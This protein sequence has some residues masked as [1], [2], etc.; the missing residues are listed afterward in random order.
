MFTN[1]LRFEDL[2]V[3]VVERRVG[4]AKNGRLYADLTVRDS[5]DGVLKCKLWS[6][7]DKHTEFTATGKVV[8]ISGEVSIYN[9]DLQGVLTQIAP[10]DKDPDEFAKRTRFSIDTMWA[11]V[12]SIVTSFD[13]PLTQYIAKELLSF[14]EPTFIRSPAARG[15]HHAWYGGLLE[16]TV[17]MSMMAFPIVA[18]Y[19][20]SYGKEKLSRDKVLFGVLMHDLGKVFEYD[21]T[22]PAFK[23]TGNGILVGHIARCAIMVNDFAT[24]WWFL[25]EEADRDEESF[26]AERDHLI[27]L[28]LSH[29][30]TNAFG[31]PVVPSSLEAIIVHQLDM[32]DSS[33]VHALELV[34][35]KEGEVKGFSDMSKTERTSF[36][37]QN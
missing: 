3:L 4:T 32:L 17:S 12:M 9:G 18:H 20:T 28:V 25:Q 8:S 21:C 13:E 6:Y 34:E 27:H 33:F 31:S 30:G 7:S 23:K 35:G 22:T 11:N 14:L 1:G 2:D 26:E 16:H 29:H 5:E 15:V 37:L 10:S 19:Q 24:K 36:L